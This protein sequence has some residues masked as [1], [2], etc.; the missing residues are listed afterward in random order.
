M[1]D[2]TILIQVDPHTRVF[3]YT[4]PPTGDDVKTIVLVNGDR[5]VWVLDP[6]LPERTFQ[7]DF[8]VLNPFRVGRAVSFRG[9]DFVVSPAVRLP[10][11]YSADRGFKYSVS[12]GNGWQDDPRC[13]V[14]PEPPDPN[15]PF[16]IMKLVKVSTTDNISWTDSSE[17]AIALSTIDIAAQ[18][19]G[20]SKTATVI[21]QWDPAQ[22]DTQP[23]TLKFTP[24]LGNSIPPGWP[25]TPQTD[26]E[27]ITL[28]L[29]P[30]AKT[31][32]RI[33]TTTPSQSP[34]VAVGTLVVTQMTGPAAMSSRPPKRRDP[35]RA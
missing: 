2:Y 23:F 9:S 6:L 27:C 14:V 4:N 25:T 18:A 7:I 20:V 8:D 22:Q 30:G 32:F 28:S 34:I 35:V 24:P 16:E 1:A 26:P 5:L 19:S 21:W 13:I 3:H 15:N 29:P 10:V 17:T 11:P 12:L 31:P 33:D